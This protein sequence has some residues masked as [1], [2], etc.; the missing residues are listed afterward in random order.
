MSKPSTPKKFTPAGTVIVAAVMLALLGIISVRSLRPSAAMKRVSPS[1]QAS[2][3]Q[4]RARILSSMASLPLAFEEN[5]GQTDAQVKYMAR[6]NGYTVFLTARDAVMALHSSSHPAKKSAAPSH[7]NQTGADRTAAIRLHLVGGNPHSTISASSQLPGH[8]NYFIG[9]D[10]SRWHAGVPQYARVSYR[11]AYPGVNMAYYGVQKQ[12][13]FDFIVA[14]G[15]SP[16]P[17]RLGVTGA[18]R[19]S[20]D[21]QGNLI[22]AS[23]SGN[24]LLHRPVAYQQSAG[25]RQPVDARFVLAV[26][27]S[28][29]F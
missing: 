1:A 26:S 27:Q 22:L 25:V 19:I 8:S 9:N 5:Q 11:D 10:R 21:E 29:E 12:L 3:P 7:T 18:N 15:A 6:G 14:P 4:D 16:N 17:I 23:S 2:A 24:V 20:T 28:G 13:E